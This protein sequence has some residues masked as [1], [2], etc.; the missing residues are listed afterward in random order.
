MTNNQEKAIME[1]VRAKA[2]SVEEV[3]APWRLC[4]AAVA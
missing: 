2:Y 1:G 4:P 3:C